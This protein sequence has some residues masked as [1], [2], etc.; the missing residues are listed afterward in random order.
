MNS[1][2]GFSIFVGCFFGRA[3]GA[4]GSWGNTRNGHVI[5]GLEYTLVSCQNSKAV[6]ICF[7]RR[8]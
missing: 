8:A 6:N 5:R 3:L 2:L 7:L 1:L 4:Q